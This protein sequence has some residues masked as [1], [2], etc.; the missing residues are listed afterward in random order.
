MNS[1]MRDLLA[2]RLKDDEPCER[3]IDCFNGIC[4]TN[5]SE[6]AWPSGAEHGSADVNI[7]RPN[8]RTVSMINE[9][10]IRERAYAL[11]EKDA[12]PEGAALFYWRL[13]QDQLAAELRSSRAAPLMQTLE[14]RKAA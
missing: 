1:H 12:C 11:W 6:A 9:S 14:K 3:V 4:S 5:R 8:H 13:A 7:Q 2:V 10:K